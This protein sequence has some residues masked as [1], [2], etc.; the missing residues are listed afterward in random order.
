MSDL[1]TVLK[2]Y[3]K[4][5]SIIPLKK[6][7][8]KPSIKWEE[9]QKRRATEDELKEWFKR[10][11]NFGIICGEVSNN[12]VVFDFDE[13]ES[14]NFVFS[15]FGKVKEKT[16]VVR[17]GKGYH[18]YFRTKKTVPSSK[19]TH[20]HLDI[21]SE[22]K[23]VVGPGSLHP[24]GAIYNSIGSEAIAE[25]DEYTAFLD[26]IDRKD[27]VYDAAKFIGTIWQAGDRHDISLRLASLLR[28]QLHW[29][30]A[31]A[32][33]FILG[34]MRM[35]DDNE[36]VQDRLRAI[37]DAYEKDYPYISTDMPKNFV[38]EILRLLP[39]DSK[40]IWRVNLNENG[41]QVIYCDPTG[42]FFLKEGKENK[43]IFPIFSTP[44]VLTDCYT[45]EGEQ[46]NDKIFSFSLGLQK[47]VGS[48]ADVVNMI[49]SSGITGINSR[50]FSEAVNA[51]VEYYIS[52]KIVIPR[53]AYP[54]VGVYNR[55]DQLITAMPG[56]KGIDIS[57]E[58]GEETYFVY[59]QFR[60]FSGNFAKS[61]S[62]LNRLWEFFP[63]RSVPLLAGYS[64]IAPFF[65]A[66]KS[67]GDL[68]TPLMI[69]KGPRGT[70][71]TTLG[72]IFTYYMYSIESGDP[73]DATSEYRLLDFVNGTTFPRLLDESENVKFEGNKFSPKASAT[74]KYNSYKQIVGTRGEIKN[75]RVQKRI[76][77]GRTPLVMAGNKIDMSDPAL[78]SRS[79]FLNFTDKPESARTLFR[80]EILA[81]L[82]KG[83]GQEIVKWISAHYTFSD[84]V[85]KIRNAKIDYSFRDSRREDLYA[86]IYAG[87]E[88]LND[89]YH[90]NGLEFSYAKLL[91]PHEFKDIVAT[92]E[93]QNTDEEEE[94]QQIQIL[95]DWAKSMADVLYKYDNIDSIP[96]NVAVL[97][98]NIKLVEDNGIK[99][100]YLGQTGLNEFCT[101]NKDI[102]FRT[103]SQAADELSKYYGAPRN[104]FYDKKTVKIDR[105]ALK[106]VKIPYDNLG[107]D[108]Y[109]GG[110][111]HSGD[112]DLRGGEQKGNQW[113]PPVTVPVT[114]LE[115]V[116][117][118]LQNKKVTSQPK[119]AHNRYFFD[120]EKIVEALNRSGY[121][122]TFLDDNDSKYS[123][124]LHFQITK[125]G[126]HI[127]NQ[128]LPFKENKEREIQKSRQIKDEQPVT[129]YY[130]S[131]KKY[132]MPY[133]EGISSH[134][135][136]S[137]HGDRFLYAIDNPFMESKKWLSF[138]TS[139]Q[140]LTKTAYNSL[141]G[142][143]EFL[144]YLPG[145]IKEI[146]IKSQLPEEQVLDM[147][148][149][150]V[151][152]G[153]VVE[154]NGI[155]EVK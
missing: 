120:R 37:E 71:K 31:D 141:V 112:N 147:L 86:E 41:S 136:I 36:E 106:V 100:I 123:N 33:E 65:F 90:E 125:K 50:Y 115:P 22:G 126:N 72:E 2:Y 91:E 80:D 38:E 35:K 49:T 150:L 97:A 60:K 18:I 128:Q 119:K 77:Y 113:L 149:S 30:I 92:I 1:E 134:V 62:T 88:I 42:V 34:I 63:S 66:L 117:S 132:D 61:L 16:M 58:Y 59:K 143:E 51:C 131:N 56:I 138:A 129:L 114:T 4:G 48:K 127:G 8:K 46:E 144:N 28:K 76:Y 21:Q 55:G 133:F 155:Y 19:R 110:G 57:P 109:G 9:F 75:R 40:E 32:K 99:W 27:A 94:R 64:V 108:D 102:A 85:N 67:T 93:E 142:H 154:N 81:N 153:R 145:N 43:S 74:L 11:S 152:N 23:Y 10:D 116:N 26:L 98:S 130:S 25:I 146:E 39:S 89:I 13:A 107:I 118:V 53:E 111:Y 47:Y 121:L 17:T 95:V 15:D 148:T 73:S 79:I 122:V 135:N 24:S 12:L 101:Q 52:K 20:L 124:I 5:L 29:E 70:G 54:A 78:I 84:L 140:P 14:V 105:H 82:E 151:L 44:L 104:V 69:L 3:R 83:F 87:L 137:P 7:E 68:Y 103:L 96:F 139:C 45:I 6:G